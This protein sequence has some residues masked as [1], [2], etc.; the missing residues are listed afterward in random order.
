[1]LF[2]SYIAGQGGGDWLLGGAGNDLLAGDTGA[3]WLFDVEGSNLLWGREGG[4]SLYDG[5]GNAL[6]IGGAGNDRITL[7]GGRDVIAFNRGDGRD[8]VRG[9]GAATLSLGGG[10]R[11]EDLALRKSGD[12]LVLEAGNGERITFRDWYADPLAQ[13]VLDMQLINE[14][15]QG[16][17]SGRDDVLGDQPVEMFDFRAIVAAFDEARAMNAN[18]GRWQILDALYQAEPR[19]F[20]NLAAG[21]DLAYQYGLRGTLAGV[22]VGSA[23]SVLGSARFG[24]AAQPLSPFDALGEGV[25]KLG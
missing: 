13:S 2:R 12:H 15:M 11:P 5:G 25:V 7:G 16:G 14:V 24:S 22:S 21:G 10:I 18:L 8:V 19:G 17:V 9:P 6:L 3:D 4:D 1:M 20:D 23:Q